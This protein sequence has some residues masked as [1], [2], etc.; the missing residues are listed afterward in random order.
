MQRE[1]GKNNTLKNE[2][3]TKQKKWGGN[4][5]TKW[6]K[7]KAIEVLVTNKINKKRHQREEQ[8]WGITCKWKERKTGARQIKSLKYQRKKVIKQHQS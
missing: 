5:T 7:E 4:K 2:I 6:K 3:L 1:C 8:K